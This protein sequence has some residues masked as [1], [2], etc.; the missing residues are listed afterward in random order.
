MAGRPIE[1]CCWCQI[2]TPSH[3][4]LNRNQDLEIQKSRLRPGYVGRSS[5]LVSP[6]TIMMSLYSIEEKEED[7]EEETALRSSLRARRP[8][9]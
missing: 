9:M 4:C 3:V 6:A 8:S 5:P 2:W 1:S 7:D